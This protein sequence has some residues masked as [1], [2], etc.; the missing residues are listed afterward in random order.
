MQSRSFHIPGPLHSRVGARNFPFHLRVLPHPWWTPRTSNRI[1]GE[2]VWS[3][4]SFAGSD[5]LQ[6]PQAQRLKPGRRFFHAEFLKHVAQ[7]RP[8]WSSVSWFPKWSAKVCTSRESTLHRRWFAEQRF[9]LTVRTRD[10]TATG[11]ES[12]S[13]E[14]AA[15]NAHISRTLS[16]SEQ[17]SWE[18]CDASGKRLWVPLLFRLWIR[19][20]SSHRVW[21]RGLGIAALS[22]WRSRLRDCRVAIAACWAVVVPHPRAA[23]S[24]RLFPER[25]WQ[26]PVRIW[27]RVGLRSRHA[28]GSRKKPRSIRGCSRPRTARGPQCRFH[29][30]RARVRTE[31]RTGQCERETSVKFWARASGRRRSRRGEQYNLQENSGASHALVTG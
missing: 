22:D 6:R 28:T 5:D 23:V 14:T 9:P 4:T 13:D 1:A 11:T 27:D 30:P 8:R 3:T 18:C 15:P 12:E 20:R 26:K 24:R 25:A 29:A 10:S 7:L 17:G 21:R 31:T 16:R 19:F 2:C